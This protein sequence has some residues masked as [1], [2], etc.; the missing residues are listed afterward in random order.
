MKTGRGSERRCRYLIR[1]TACTGTTKGALCDPH[2]GGKARGIPS[3][4]YDSSIYLGETR[5]TM[6]E[7]LKTVEMMAMS[8]MW[9]GDAYLVD[10]HNCVSFAQML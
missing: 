8:P 7:V 6:R 5:L 2:T 1:R 10:T 3:S 9:H 4:D